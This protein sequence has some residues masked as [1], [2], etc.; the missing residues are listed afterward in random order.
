MRRAW[1]RIACIAFAAVCWA[2]VASA[3]SPAQ[4]VPSAI[5][6]YPNIVAEGEFDTRVMMVNLSSRD[7]AVKCHYLPTGS[8][9]GTDFF[10]SLTPNQPVSWLARSGSI[11]GQPGLQRLAIP[12][13]FGEG[14]LK[15][16]VIP[17]EGGDEHQNA[18]QGRATVFGPDGYT[19]SIGAIGIERLTPGEFSNVLELDGVTYAQCPDEYHFTFLSSEPGNPNTESEL[20]LSTCDE[21]LENL[22]TRNVVVQFQIINEFEQFLSASTSVRCHSRQVLS[23]INSVFTR[24]TLG[25]PTG[26]LIVRGVQ[27]PVIAVLVD[28][29]ETAGGAAAAAGNEP[30]LSGGRP[31]RIIIP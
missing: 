18:I 6:M 10:V 19:E 3:N 4:R 8:C 14:S 2:G 11:G 15:C 5:L 12:P 20:I 9:L 7:Q 24:D 21:D 23:Q 31:A 28:K 29:F 17:G 25:T 27:G 16:V 1:I 13:F 22:I 30:A 26:Q